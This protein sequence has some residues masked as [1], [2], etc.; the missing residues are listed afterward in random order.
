VTNT[1]IYVVDSTARRGHLIRWPIDRPTSDPAW[2]HDSR[3]LAFATPR[4]LFEVSAD[5]RRRG[6]VTLDWCKAASGG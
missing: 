2:S 5:G 4:G 6:Y 1:G 3:T